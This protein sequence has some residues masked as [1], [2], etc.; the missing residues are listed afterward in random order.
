MRKNP[1]IAEI[2]QEQMKKR[3]FPNFR[4][5]DSLK[6]YTRIVEGNKERVQAF[7]G[8]VIA[9]KGQGISQT[10]SLYRV[11]YG[12]AMEKVFLLHSPKITKIEKIRSGK[13]RRAKLYYLRGTSGKAAKVKAI[14]DFSK[15]ETS[16]QGPGE[17]EQKGEEQE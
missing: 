12:S 15:E 16:S 3:D 11:A 7:I 13:V 4:V 5:G 8:T 2:E 1:R 14:I 9:K 10:I 6:I 17:L